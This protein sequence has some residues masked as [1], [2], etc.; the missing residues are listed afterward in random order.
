MK[1]DQTIVNRF[2][3]LEKGIAQVEATI[4][5]DKFGHQHVKA[6]IFEEWAT[7]VESLLQNVFREDAVY[8]KN[9]QTHHSQF[10]GKLGAV[11]MCIGAFRAARADFEAGYLSKVENLISAEVIDDILE[12]GQELLKAKYVGP[13]CVIA[14]VALETTLKKLCD[15]NRFLTRNSTK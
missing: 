4:W 1:V 9:F 14:G 2:S 13:A 5:K 12:Q 8:F 10:T 3:E 7:R 11:Q 15:R 6:S